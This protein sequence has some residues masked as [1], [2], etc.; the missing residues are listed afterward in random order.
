MSFKKCSLTLKSDIK[1]FLQDISEKY[2]MYNL[3]LPSKNKKGGIPR[4]L[5]GLLTIVLSI[6]L[7]NAQ[8]TRSE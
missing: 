5:S 8:F 7:G 1:H 6:T 3:L 4:W 2:N